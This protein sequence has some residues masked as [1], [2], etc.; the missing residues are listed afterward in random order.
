MKKEVLFAIGIGVALG[1]I[2]TFA[3]YSFRS[4]P[5]KNFSFVSPLPDQASDTSKIPTQPTISPSLTLISPLDE[6]I[7]KEGKTKIVGV[8]PPKSWILILSE[9]GEKLLQTDNQGN[10]ETEITLISGE[11]E[12]EVKCFDQNQEIANKI[13]TVVY[14]TAEI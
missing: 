9:K 2:L 14:S 11:N 8:A 6:S 12:I 13:I 3:I 5:S 1:L 7:S 10:F 4:S